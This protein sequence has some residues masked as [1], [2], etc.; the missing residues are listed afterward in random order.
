MGSLLAHL[1]PQTFKIGRG[2]TQIPYSFQ[3]FARRVS[4]ANEG[5]NARNDGE[6]VHCFLA[7]KPI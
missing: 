1:V 2:V 5:N 6:W 3:S 4:G 7:L